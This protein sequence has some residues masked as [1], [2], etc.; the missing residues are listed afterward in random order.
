MDNDGYPG[1]IPVSNFNYSFYTDQP[2]FDL[3]DDLQPL[4]GGL[5]YGVAWLHLMSN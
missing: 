3:I 1:N 4:A 5:S 2:P